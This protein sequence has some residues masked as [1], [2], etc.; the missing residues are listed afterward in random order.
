MA[1]RLIG[2]DRAEPPA[3][4][5]PTGLAANPVLSTAEDSPF[6]LVEAVPLAQGVAPAQAVQPGAPPPD[7]RA[8]AQ[9]R[10]REGVFAPFR[11]LTGRF[12]IAV[13]DLGSGHGVY[14]N[15]GFAFQAASLY[16]LPVMYEV[17]KQREWGLVTFREE[18][19][20]APEDAA[21]DLGTLFWPVGTRITV[22]TAL[23]RMVTISDNSTAWMLARRVGS[24]A[25]INESMANLDLVH[26]RIQGDDLSTS[27]GDMLLFLER[28]A[29]GE[30]LDPPT[31][32]EMVHLMARQQVRNRIPVLLPPE[33][34]VANKTGN[35]EGAA[36]D[37]AIIYGPRATLVCA[38][39]SDG[40][41]DFEAVYAAMA[42]AARNA[43]DVLHDPTVDTRANPPLPPPAVSSYAAAPR[44]PA[45]GN[46]ATGPTVVPGQAPP[47]LSAPLAPQGPVAPP[48]L[49]TAPNTPPTPAQRHVPV[50]PPPTVSNP[51]PAP[52]STR[53]APAPTTPPPSKP[54]QVPSTPP[55][56]NQAQPIF[57]APSGNG[58]GPGGSGLPPIPAVPPTGVQKP[59]P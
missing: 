51:A 27:A 21:M 13:K 24:S 30:A 18:L 16:K 7:P 12:G 46:R 56:K 32:A 59:G 22:G 36:H 31:S 54:A 1:V 23:E 49:E 5:S 11:G 45:V 20:I 15:E 38:F 14:L 58:P 47:A 48:R 34:T 35:W 43:Y 57:V 28:L 52:T 41:D 40:L 37:V 17:F 44:L 26:T 8:V 6:A 19:T 42:R 3:P 9:W 53:Q 33:A 55:S 25:K 29:R 2:G 39:L 50:A 4:A 10:L